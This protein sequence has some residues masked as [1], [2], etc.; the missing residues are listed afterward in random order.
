MIWRVWRVSC[1]CCRP[2]ILPPE[3]PRR[4]WS[5]RQTASPARTP[6]R[7]QTRSSCCS[8]CSIMTTRVP[9]AS[10]PSG[11][12]YSALPME[13]M[14]SAKF[15][16]GSQEKPAQQLW[17]WLRLA[18]TTSGMNIATQLPASISSSLD[19]PRSSTR[20][21]LNCTSRPCPKRAI[22]SSRSRSKTV[23]N[24]FFMRRV[25]HPR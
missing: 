9:S 5:E 22:T 4:D 21:R 1:S 15:A 19:P 17:T 14:K 3:Q 13:F 18:I 24:R 7:S 11:L 20:I 2:Q 8:D 6:S 10:R 12:T 16:A 23:S 25:W